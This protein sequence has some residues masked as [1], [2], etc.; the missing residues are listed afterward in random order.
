MLLHFF[1]ARRVKLYA[2]ILS[3]QKKKKTAGTRIVCD[4]KQ[5]LRYFMAGYLASYNE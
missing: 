1:C 4:A 3:P 5:I 2:K